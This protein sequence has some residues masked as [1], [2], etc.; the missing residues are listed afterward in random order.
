MHSLSTIN[1]WCQFRILIDSHSGINIQ[2]QTCFFSFDS[3]LLGKS[4]GSYSDL[5][6]EK[7]KDNNI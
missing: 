7:Y 3:C 2:L 1:L 4:L 5:T 6:K